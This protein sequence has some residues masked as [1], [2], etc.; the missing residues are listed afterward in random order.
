MSRL[1]SRA[2][3]PSRERVEVPE[4]KTSRAV[5]S[6]IWEGWGLQARIEGCNLLFLLSRVKSSSFSP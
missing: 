3:L 1:L 5:C 2:Y 4:G 6:R